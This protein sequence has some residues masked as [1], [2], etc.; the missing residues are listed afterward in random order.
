MAVSIPGFGG[1]R[2]DRLA[3]DQGA[4]GVAGAACTG[5]RAGL[6]WQRS[7]PPFPPPARPT[8]T[9]PAALS[10]PP[11]PRPAAK[12]ALWRRSW[13]DKILPALARFQPDLIFVCAGALP[14]AW[15]GRG[16]GLR[17]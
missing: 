1:G 11:P 9:P 4:P 6:A 12:P 13:R 17:L 7:L 8:L 5:V 16:A 2:R 3:L 15:A 10:P 14:P